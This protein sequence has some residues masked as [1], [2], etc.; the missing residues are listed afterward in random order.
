MSMI[1]AKRVSIGADEIVLFD[2]MMNLLCRMPYGSL[3]A[4]AAALDGDADKFQQAI[5]T[6]KQ[7]FVKSKDEAAE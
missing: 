5:D 1:G 3:L 7:T 6:Y 4:F 2:D